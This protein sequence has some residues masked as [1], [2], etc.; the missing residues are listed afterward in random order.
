KGGKVE[1]SFPEIGNNEIVSFP[2]YRDDL[3][4]M[5]YFFARLPIEYLFHDDRINP[6]AVGGSLNSL[7]EEFHRKRPQLHVALAWATLPDGD[8]KTRVRVFDGQH[9][10]TAQ[11]LL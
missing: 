7:V 6:R 8:A 9:K 5:E 4:G 2:V 11:V 3:S 1:M 10:A